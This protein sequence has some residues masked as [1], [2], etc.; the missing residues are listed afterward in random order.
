MSKP[1]K[2]QPLK[3]PRYRGGQEALQKIITENLKYPTGALDQKVEGSVEAAYDVDGL[4]RIK[5]VRILSGL[6]HGCDEEV[7]RLINMLVY[8]KAVN[9]GR[10][11]TAHKKLK[12]DFKLPKA[13]PKKTQLQYHY[14][15]EKTSAQAAPVQKK[16]G[17]YVI[18]VNVKPK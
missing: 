7:M 5:N 15:P 8:E 14:V 9:P 18:S 16:K 3:M 11:V 12:V 6:G 10:N 17:G 2:D 4:G 13:R 1:R